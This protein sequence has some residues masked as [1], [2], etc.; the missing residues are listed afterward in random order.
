MPTGARSVQTF[1]SAYIDS[2]LNNEIDYEEMSS[3]IK[4]ASTTDAEGIAQV[5]APKALELATHGPGFCA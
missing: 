1:D 3:F 2:I 4:S 5:V